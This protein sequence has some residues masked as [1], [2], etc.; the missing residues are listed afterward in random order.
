MKRK[1]FYN[2]L[3]YIVDNRVKGYDYPEST[4]KI[5]YGV[6][7]V[8]LKRKEKYFEITFLVN[9]DKYS[10]FGKKEPGS[11]KIFKNDFIIYSLPW[12][13]RYL[14]DIMIKFFEK[15]VY[16]E[17]V[18][19]KN[20]IAEC[21][22][23]RKIKE[24]NR[25]PH[26]DKY[27]KM[28][29]KILR[30]LGHTYRSDDLL[31]HNASVTEE[32][33]YSGYGLDIFAYDLPGYD[34]VDEVNGGLSNLIDK[35]MDKIRICF[36]DKKVFDSDSEFYQKGIWEE[37]FKELYNKSDILIAEKKEKY[38]TGMH[39]IKII[40]N[41]IL[42]LCY[43]NIRKVN[44]T[45]N[46]KYYTEQSSRVNNCGSFENDYHYKVVK[47]GKTVFHAVEVSW[48]RYSIISYTPGTWESELKNYL[49]EL[50]KQ[51]QQKEYNDGL[52]YI[53]QLKKIK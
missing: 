4:R 15:D 9:V 30:G 7:N 32:C 20:L 22:K 53:K 25:D 11:I 1:N 12:G 41:I 34:Y 19:Y 10:S 28:A 49:V 33:L 42:P 24:K 37:V 26:I 23:K 16:N 50:E 17:V 8:R 14:L 39:C 29:K 21:E 46:I 18:N 51:D 43:K 6:S 48:D 13:H 27:K 44:D 40:D 38:K 36:K 47:D 3:K 31:D 2:V 5:E 35:Y 45:I 52:E